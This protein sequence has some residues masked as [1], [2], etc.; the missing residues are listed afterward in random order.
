MKVIK[1]VWGDVLLLEPRSHED[2]RGFFLENYHYERYK[3]VGIE[4]VFIQDNHSYSKD[5]G[6]LRGMH[7]QRIEKA[8]SKLVRVITGAVYDVVIDIRKGSPTYGKW[9]GF[10]LS[11]FNKRLLYVPKGFAHGFCTLTPSTHVVYKVDTYYSPEHDQGV[12]WCDPDIGITWPVSH[13]ILSEKDR[14]QPLLAEIDTSF[15]YNEASE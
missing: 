15:T 1:K 9:A 8:Q 4:E 5:P 2:H 3:D 6:V 7:Y 12:L 10:I 14:N 11:E 13:P